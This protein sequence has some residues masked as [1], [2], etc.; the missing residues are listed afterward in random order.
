MYLKVN[1]K[2]KS[3]HSSLD[4]FKQTIGTEIPQEM[5]TDNRVRIVN[6]ATSKNVFVKSTIFHTPTFRSTYGPFP[7]GKKTHTTKFITILSIGHGI[8][9]YTPWRRLWC[10]EVYLLIILDFGTRWGRMVSRASDALST[11][12]VMIFYNGYWILMGG[13]GSFLPLSV[14]L[15]MNRYFSKYA[16]SEPCSWKEV[17]QHTFMVI[18]ASIC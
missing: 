1:L 8:S 7:R 6:F 10:E 18:A 15:E 2:K 12:V 3:L 4:T 11:F 13:S 16:R 9:V 5:N 14:D 17:W